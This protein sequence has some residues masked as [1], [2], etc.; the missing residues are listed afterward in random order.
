MVE[1][2]APMTK[3][4]AE[5]SEKRQG[6][7]ETLLGAWL[8]NHPWAQRLRRLPESWR[9]AGG[10]GL[11]A[12]LV[13]VPYVGA[14][15][16]WDPWETHYGE[17]AREMIARADYVYPFQDSGDVSTSGWFFSKPP[18]TMWMEVPGMLLVGIEHGDGKLPLYTEWAMRLPFALTSAAALALL[19]WALARTVNRRVGVTAAFVL[20][21][22]PLYFL[23]TRQ[24]VTDTPFVAALIAAMAC[25]LIG[26]FDT[27]TRHRAAWWYAFYVLLGLS[28]L[29]KG[30]LGVALPAV[31]LV[32][33][34]G[35]FVFPWTRESIESHARWLGQ[36]LVRPFGPL[37]RRLPGGF[38]GP[39]ASAGESSTPVL[40]AE[41][42][43]MRLFSG[44]ALFFAVCG[45]WYL[46]LSLFPAVDSENKTFFY[47]FFIHDHFNR[48]LEGVHTTTPGGTF[49]YFIEQGGF[50]IFPWV[51]LL[52][53]ALAAAARIRLGAQDTRTRV[54]FIAL[55][56]TVVAFFVVDISATKFHHY[57]LPVL[58][59]VAILLALFVDELWEDGIAAHG[60]SLLLGL[61]FFILVGKDLAE[62]PKNFT[63]L[64][65]YNYERPY[66]F[67]LDTRPIHFGDHVLS[68]GD[69]VAAVL[70]AA[71]V[72]LF[73][74][75]SSEREDRWSARASA[76]VLA[77]TGLAALFAGKLPVA[78]P[79]LV[80]SIAMGA[81]AAA[82]LAIGVRQKGPARRSALWMA[83]SIGAT[84]AVLLFAGMRLG[85]SDP[86]ILLIRTPLNVKT[87]MGWAFTL[88]GGA[89]AM[90][91]LRRAQA[92]LFTGFVAL[93]LGFAL[94]FSWSRWVDLSHHWTQRDLFWRYYDQRRPSEPIAAYMMDWKGETFYS[95]NTV[96]Q[97][98][99]SAP[100]L[101]LY[102]Q[103]PG[104]K[105]AL[106]EQARLGLVRQAV[107]ADKVV[108]PIDRNLNVKFVLVTIE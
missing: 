84:A 104:R 65:V 12:A 87:G 10:A 57:V 67:E 62:N 2:K 41:M 3:A 53:G 75:G 77:A 58:P 97:D 18:L 32:L 4:S 48:L 105:W 93:S 5:P 96:R 89:L 69:V 1:A 33:Y 13:F 91:A 40:F 92:E 30:L 20:A 86:L 24:A 103:L 28:T 25:A 14:V 60:V 108:T 19:A 74:G 70:L 88:A 79:L 22:M 94:W 83:C 37:L 106:V 66:P 63:D 26:L 15:G 107:G 49:I 55:A 50:A 45:P 90:A 59:G 38:G 35:F 7:L 73:L 39:P 95:R 76:A 64:F 44:I 98:K 21:T 99:D 29:S 52:P 42:A 6:I 72:Y 100:R 11:I 54:A 47:R 16:L 23:I 46:T 81:A 61:V 101:T 82:T 51:A 34:A 56:W 9:I 17:V 102:G 80:W 68:M 31:I 43:R 78:S 8:W 85:V 36:R 71:A 27:K